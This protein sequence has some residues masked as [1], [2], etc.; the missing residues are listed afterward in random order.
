MGAEI[1]EEFETNE[2][3]DDM[4]RNSKWEMSG[5]RLPMNECY[6]SFV[7]NPNGR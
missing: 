2:I 1:Q 6:G 4:D 3:A 5:L 7:I